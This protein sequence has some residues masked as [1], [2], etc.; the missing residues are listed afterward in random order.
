MAKYNNLS[1][2]TWTFGVGMVMGPA[3]YWIRSFLSVWILFFESHQIWVESDLKNKNGSGLGS[4]PLDLDP[5]LDPTSR[6]GP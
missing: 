5:D 4:R 3:P 6:C 1:N 2:S